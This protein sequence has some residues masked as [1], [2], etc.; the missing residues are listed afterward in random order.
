MTS[1]AAIALGSEPS[2]TES[3][4]MVLAKGGTSVDACIA[5][6]FTAAGAHPG[7]LL[8]CVSLLV[9]GTGVGEHL[10]D[11]SV[12]QPGVGAPRPRGF[13]QDDLIPVSARIPVAATGAML[14]AVHAYGGSIPM[15]ELAT[16]GVRLAQAARAAG[17]AHLLRRVGD[18]GPVALRESSFVR[19]LLEIGG[20]HEGGNVTQQDLADVQASILEPCRM[21]GV[22]H[23]SA[24]PFAGDV[25]ELTC[26][27]MM[28][29]DPRGV[30]AVMHCAF[31]PQGP[32]VAP[33]QVTVSR[34]AVPVRRGIPRV[35]PGSPIR[36]PIPIALLMEGRTPWA[37]VGIHKV[38]AVDWQIVMDRVK[39][40][41]SLEQSLR[42]ALVDNHPERR[43]FAIVRATGSGAPRASE[44][45]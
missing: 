15:S 14:S 23:A 12:V 5:G 18:A 31:D 39:A 40:D 13:Q 17:R 36:L 26:L 32:E 44:I 10:F 11:G 27:M 37:A 4:R 33:H 30:L 35:R 22:I 28:A 34:L 41:L 2:M 6:F 1:R 8:G 25:P 38:E 45:K 19:A 43:V 16:P 9:A 29:S 24:E 7:V 42:A 21:Q 20:R 3:A